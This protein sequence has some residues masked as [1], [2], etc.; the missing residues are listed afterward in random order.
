MVLANWKRPPATTLPLPAGATTPNTSASALGRPRGQR[1]GGGV[2]RG[3]P[4]AQL[5]ADRGEGAAEVERVAVDV[6]AAHPAVRVRVE[7]GDQR[8]GGG[9]QRG[10]PRPGGAVDRGELAAD[11]DPGAVGR[12]VQG[13]ALGVQRRRPGGDQRA[14][15]QVVGEQ[16]GP[17]GL[18][19]AGGGAGRA[20][21][22]EVAGDVHPVAD[23]QLVPD[24]AVDLHGGQR[25][26]GDGARRGRGRRAVRAGRRGATSG[27]STA[28]SAAAARPANR[29]RRG[30]GDDP[31]IVV[32]SRGVGSG[33]GRRSAPD[34]HDIG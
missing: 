15:A 17:R 6:D 31:G 10:Q 12:G 4:G 26:G 16:V 7:A 19:G 5:A 28:T 13:E 11:V 21:L 2:D 34:E 30:P 27:A 24:H 23:D 3:Q 32:P 8:A 1:A 9:V 20:G 33:A 22:A 29:R 25:V 18:L 14:V